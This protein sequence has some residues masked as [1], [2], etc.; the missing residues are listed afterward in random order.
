M[1]LRELL[2][3]RL[4]PPDEGRQRTFPLDEF[5]GPPRIMDDRLDFAAVADDPFVY[6]QTIEVALGEAREGYA[7]QDLA[8]VALHLPRCDRA[9]AASSR[10]RA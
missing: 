1:R 10:V 3:V 9:R 6:E 7:D 8:G 5:L 4:V 2:R